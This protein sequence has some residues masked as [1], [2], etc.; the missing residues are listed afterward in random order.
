MESAD[1]REDLDSATLH[2]G[3]RPGLA[4]LARAGDLVAES[5]TAA[6]KSLLLFGALPP[7]AF[8]YLMAEKY[9]QHPDLVVSMVAIGNVFALIRIPLVLAFLL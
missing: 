2:P 6:A 8:N 7:A 3:Y 9:H 1:C 4:A 5:R